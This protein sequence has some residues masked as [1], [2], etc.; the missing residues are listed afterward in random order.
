[1][2]RNQEFRVV[3]ERV[4]HLNLLHRAFLQHAT[5]E[6]GLFMGQLPIIKYV[7][8]HDGCTQVELAKG[9]MVSAPSIATSIKRMQRNGLLERKRSDSDSRSNRISITGKGLELGRTCRKVFDA[10]NR[11]MFEGFDT[12]DFTVLS[13]YIERM[14]DNIDTSGPEGNPLVSAVGEIR[15]ENLHA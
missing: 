6:R 11:K 7:S 9:L 4:A 2:D 13:G 1:M 3:V 14:I 15:K 5:L 8:E 10:V 12:R